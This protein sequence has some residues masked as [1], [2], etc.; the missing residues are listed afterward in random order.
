MF[1]RCVEKI[2]KD[3]FIMCVGRDYCLLYPMRL[4]G[5]EEYLKINIMI[6]HHVPDVIL[7]QQPL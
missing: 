7:R 4:T 1:C 2:R 3:Y 5:K 6:M